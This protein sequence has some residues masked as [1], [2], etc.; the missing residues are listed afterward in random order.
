MSILSAKE[1]FV[2]W[3]GD[4]A[5]WPDYTRKVRFQ[6]EKTPRK[7]RHLLGAELASRLSGRAWSVTHEL[8]HVKLGKRNGAK[9][10]LKYLQER[11]CRTAV[12]DAGARLEDLLIRLRRPYGM[13]MSQWANEVQEAY[14]KV[15][16]ALV[17]ARQQAQA[18]KGGSAPTSPQKSSSARSEPQAEPPSPTRLRSPTA[19]RL[20]PEQGGRAEEP[21]RDDPGHQEGEPQ[22]TVEEFVREEQVE[23]PED[24]QGWTVEEWREW[25]QRYRGGDDDEEDASSGEDLPWDE[26][27]V[28]NLQVLPDEVL[29]WLLLRRA[30][31]S[32]SSRLSVQASVQNSL[33]FRDIELA[34]RDQEEELL[35]ADSHRHQGKRRTF[36]VEEE[37]NWG[38]LAVPDDGQ[39][40]VLQ[41]VHWVGTQLPPEV[42]D[43]GVVDYN[44]TENPEIYW[45]YEV[46][47]WHGYLQ[48]SMGY[49]VETDGLGTFWSAEEDD[50]S[51]LSSDQVKELE[52]AY[53]VY[54][55]KMRTFQQSRQLQRA[56][57]G[58]RGFYPMPM[59]KGKMKG[60]G[61]GKNKSKG[62]KSSSVATSSTTSPTRTMFQAQG[63]PV[64]NE[65]VMMAGSNDGCFICGDRGHGFRNCPKRNSASPGTTGGKGSHKGAFW[66]ESLTPSSLIFMAQN[67]ELVDS[68]EGFGVLDLG[69]TETVASLEALHQLMALRGGGERVRVVPAGKR[70]FRF[71]NGCVQYSESFVMIPQKVGTHEVLLGIFTLDAEKVPILLGMKTL[72]K[73]GAIIDVRGRWLVLSAVDGGLKIPLRKSRA[74]HLLVDLTQDWMATGQPLEV[75]DR[76]IG[77]AYMV[78]AASVAGESEARGNEEGDVNSLISMSVEELAAFALHPHDRSVGDLHDEEFEDEEVRNSMQVFDNNTVLFHED[79]GWVSEATVDQG[80]RDRILSALARPS[81][82][83]SDPHSSHGAQEG[84][85]AYV[86]EVRLLEDTGNQSRGSQGS[87]P[88]MYGEPYPGPRGARLS[89]GQQQVGDMDRLRSLRNP[90]TI[91][92]GLW[93]SRPMPSSRTFASGCEEASGGEEARERI[94]GAE[95]SQDWLRRGGAFDG[96]QVAGDSQAEGRLP[97]EARGEEQR[98]PQGAR[99]GEERG[100]SRSLSQVTFGDSERGPAVAEAEG[101]DGDHTRSQS[102]TRTSRDSRGFGVSPARSRRSDHSERRRELGEDD[103]SQR[104]LGQSPSV[105]RDSRSPSTR[106]SHVS[107]TGPVRGHLHASTDA[108][109]RGERSRSR[110]VGNSSMSLSTPSPSPL[111]REFSNQDDY[112]DYKYDEEMKQNEHQQAIFED[113]PMQAMLHDVEQCEAKM[114]QEETDFLHESLENAVQDVEQQFSEVLTATRSKTSSP[115]VMEL[116]CEMDSGITAEMEK[117]FG[118]GVRCGIHNGCD[119]LKGRGLS[120][121]LA[122]LEETR[123][124]VL[125]VSFPCGPTS[126]LQELN[127][128]DEESIARIEKKVARSRRLV[129]NGLVV[130]ERQLE[131]GGEVLQEWPLGNKA[132]NF[133]SIREFWKK[134][135]REG[136][137]FEARVDGCAYGLQ[138]PEGYIKKPWLLRSTSKWVWSMEKRCPGLHVHD[139]VPCEGGQRARLSALYPKAMCKRVAYV[140]RAIHNSLREMVPEEIWAIHPEGDPECLKEHTEQELMHWARELM[141]LHKKLGHP[142]RQSFVKMLRDRG[143]SMKIITLASQMRCQDCDEATVPP[144]RKAVTLEVASSTWEC[145]QLDIMEHTVGDTTYKFLVFIDEASSYGAVASLGSHHVKQSLGTTTAKMVEVL[146]QTWIQYFGFPKKIKLDR[147]GTFRG[148][149]L[150]EMCQGNGVE[151]E[152][153]PAEEHGSIGQV[154]RLIGSLKS[155]LQRFL[156]SSDMDPQVACWAMVAAHNSMARVGGFSPCQWVF[157]RDF[158]DA[159]RLHDGGDLPYWSSVAVDERF[160]RKNQIRFEA[161]QAYLKM[162]QEHKMNQA[163]NTRMPLPQRYL[164]GDL[165]YYKR[166]QAPRDSKSHLELDTSRRSVARWFGPAR[167]LALETKVTYEGQVRQPHQIAW[168]IAAGRLKRV[169]V[170]QLRH[171]SEREKVVAE[172]HPFLATPWTFGS[173]IKLLDKGTY[174]EEVEDKSLRRGPLKNPM[175]KLRRSRSESR[176]RGGR[177]RALSPEEDPGRDGIE[178]LYEDGDLPMPTTPIPSP[179]EKESD[180]ETQPIE[181][182]DDLTYSDRYSDLPVVRNGD[183]DPDPQR[184]VHDPEYYQMSRPVRAPLFQHDPFLR[185][186]QRHEQLERPHHVQRQDYMDSLEQQLHQDLGEINYTIQ[187]PLKGSVNFLEPIDLEDMIFGVTLPEPETE[188]EW[189]AVVK[190]PNKFVAKKVAK[191]VEVSWNKLSPLQRSAMKEAKGVEISEWLASK[192][193]KAAVGDIPQERLMKMRWVLTF[194]SA[195]LGKVKAKARL[196]VVGFTDP[197]YAMVTTASPTLSRRSRQMT[198]QLAC[199]RG[200]SLLK[201]DAKAAFLQGRETQE[202]RCIFGLPVEELRVAMNLPHGRAVQFLKAAY[203]LTI[204]PREFYLLVND[205]LTDLKAVRL[206]TEPCLWRVQDEEGHTIG[207]IGAHVDDFLLTGQESHPIW[208][209]FLKDF[210]KALRW[211][212]WEVAPMVHCGVRLQQLPDGGW[213]MDQKEYCEGINQ[214]E[215]DGKTKELTPGERQQCRAVL[216]AVQWRVYQSGP[217]HAA[218]LSHLQSIL[219]NADRS[220][221]YE[222]NKLVREVFSQKEVGIR[223]NQ[224]MAQHDDDLIIIAWSDAALANRVDLGSTGGYLIGFAHRDMLDGKRGP[225][226]PISWGSHK[227]RRVCRSSLAAETQA[228]SEAEQEMMYIRTQWREMLGDEVNLRDAEVIAA[229]TTG[230]L[231]TDA[232]ALYDAASGGLLQSSGFSMREKYTAL[233]LLGITEHI[234]AQRTILR[235][236]N[237]DAQLADGLTK[238]QAQDRIRKF[239]QGGQLWNLAYDENFTSAKRLRQQSSMARS[240]DGAGEVPEDDGMRDRSWLELLSHAT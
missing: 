80:M 197:D 51:H 152:A 180:E 45:N 39:D 19:R 44:E 220:V 179:T 94:S 18:R 70:P 212:P 206:K 154:E 38:L 27:Q 105:L 178:D 174:D 30:N 7:K 210:H 47:G 21:Q 41:E 95:Q 60:K 124:D 131:L 136:R 231:V 193:C 141:K 69:A 29:G 49:W 90:T 68:T 194:K 167:V 93:S 121:T 140:V 110:G 102:P 200:W 157:G 34:L 32:A 58:S 55:G 62:S 153:I 201:A 139:H 2:T 213:M 10:L 75:L 59:M 218:K 230:V 177:K 103:Q 158:T 77:G 9:Y 5:S 117:S 134:R 145:L 76:P 173:L 129:R 28:E 83:P 3:D 123:P 61:K 127:K 72:E 114:E 199:H 192:V 88:T 82:R 24:L 198:L 238:L 89:D 171:A 99:E 224:L 78:S 138:V 159:D 126:M 185:A 111:R 42:Y 33:S 204:A 104:G 107:T 175:K 125:W 176:G 100:L 8:D 196:V 20:F 148:R 229:K 165:V 132:W 228:L 43:P 214:V 166:Y 119:L 48:D 207:L 13:T 66:I 56:K 92:S 81:S 227:L 236:C 135:D 46:D 161:Q 84:E 222:V 215:A 143:A 234:V 137:A 208:E 216:G 147:E 79:D 112:E 50:W 235:W 142:S 73:L 57:G 14:R 16:R 144:S 223:V 146:F 23:E 172:H 160:H 203:G 202:Q 97:E 11:L 150:E 37:G 209:K 162:N 109:I 67:D 25:R 190:D 64:G 71:G 221:I 226:N 130:M 120:K 184:M 181:V 6:F 233:E 128:R 170:T 164:P 4:P 86:R 101:G 113:E 96:G 106:R 53:S 15:Q 35:Q 225:V 186:R 91:H 17:R 219:P 168:I 182:D 85:G 217:Q 65:N 189:R 205:I 122:M 26:L 188:A 108:S 239:L 87:R 116:C 240:H 191:G 31:L 98:L 133:H 211:S 1:I 156:R 195:D 40:D 183:E 22:Q 54:D 12:P 115:T 151:L 149:E 187:V 169:T 163:M 237:S 155:K 118:V 36:W 63:G 52:E 232:K 74:G